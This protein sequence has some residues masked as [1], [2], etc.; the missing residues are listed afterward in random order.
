MGDD[1]GVLNGR[2]DRSAE[3]ERHNDD[4]KC[5][6]LSTPGQRKHEQGDQRSEH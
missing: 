6:G 4:D 3:D 5:S 1:L 2:Q